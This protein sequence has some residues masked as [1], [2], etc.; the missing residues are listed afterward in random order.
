[1][2]KMTVENKIEDPTI[3]EITLG[4]L[5]HDIGKFAQRAGEET[6]KSQNME[7]LVKKLDPK[8]GRYTHEHAL[9]T[10][11]VVESLRNYLPARIRYQKVANLAASHHD[12]SNL[13]ETIIQYGDS[14]SAGAERKKRDDTETRDRGKKFFEIPLACILDSIQIPQIP[15]IEQRYYP[16][17]PLT[18]DSIFAQTNVKLSQD[19]YKK[20]WDLFYKDMQQLRDLEFGNYLDAL[21]SIFERY[22]WCI[23]SST[24]DEPDISLYD[25]TVTTAAFASCLYQYYTAKGIRELSNQELN[26]KEPVFLFV[27]GDVSGIQSYIFNLKTTD[28]NA[29]LLRARS[30]EIELLTNQAAQLITETLGLTKV[31]ILTNAAGQFLI[32]CGNTEENRESITKIRAQIEQYFFE[33]FLGELSLNLS[34]PV[35]SCIDD[36]KLEVFPLLLQKIKNAAQEAKQKKFYSI[37]TTVNAHILHNEYLKIQ[38]TQRIC[39]SCDQR[40]GDIHRDNDYYCRSCN[41][42][43]KI[44][45]K[46]PKS[47]AVNQRSKETFLGVEDI[48]L[49]EECPTNPKH[50]FAYSINTYKPGFGWYHMPYHI[51]KN[52]NGVPLTFEELAQR[53]EGTK[54]IAMFKAD[55]DNLG[56][57]FSLGF[58]ERISISRYAALS[59]TLHYFFSTYLNC[60]IETKYPSDIYTVFSG[61]DDVCVIGPW[62]KVLDFA[63]ELHREFLRFVGGNP[64]LTLSAGISLAHHNLPVRTIAHEAEEALKKSKEAD[65]EMKEKNRITVFHTSVKWNEYRTLLEEARNRLWNYLQKKIMTKAFLYRLLQYHEMHQTITKLQKHIHRNA[66]WLSHFYYDLARNV[67]AKKYEQESEYLKQFVLKHIETLRIPVSYVLYRARNE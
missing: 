13:F 57:V 56:V 50:Q 51:P 39:K 12:P 37:L 15:T 65:P 31:C 28:S 67:E 32:V 40:S 60:F 2:E 7:G 44:G 16:L 66:L 25:H 30:F 64:S 49:L 18:P 20:L 5:F 41:R 54:K 53:S 63:E 55:M 47:E 6:F 29:K 58:K 10:L 8:T 17:S 26:R 48:L 59:R 61:G 4:A 11:G 52:Q 43:I 23:P 46:L 3:Q 35:S 21:L 19:D 38:Q 33:N 1:M 9:Y 34:E 42:L 22:L 36:L 45:E 14:I 24:I 62:N 27:H